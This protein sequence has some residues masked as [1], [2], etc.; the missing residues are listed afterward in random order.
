MDLIGLFS[1]SDHSIEVHRVG[2]KHQK[3]F[4]KEDLLGPTSLEFTKN[5]RQ[6]IIGY[7]DGKISLIKSDDSASEIF[8]AKIVDDISPITALCY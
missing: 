1:T 2:F 3:V 8:A 5:G 6:V 7:E 4:Q